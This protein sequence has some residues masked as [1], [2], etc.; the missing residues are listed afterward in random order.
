MNLSYRQLQDRMHR[1]ALGS[2]ARPVAWFAI[3]MMLFFGLM[4]A[5][6]AARLPNAFS[7]NLTVLTLVAVTMCYFLLQDFRAVA[8][9]PQDYEVLGHRPVSPRTYLLVRLTV[10][11][12]QQAIMTALLAGPSAL[13][14]GFRFGWPPA[15]ALFLAALL[16]VFCAV[17]LAL[18]TFATVIEKTGGKW[19]ARALTW[20]QLA[21]I[22]LYIGPLL[23]ES[24]VTALMEG[25]GVG[26]QGWLLALPTAWFAGLAS[27]A[28]GEFT[29]CCWAASAC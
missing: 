10:I 14:C 16:L 22:A 6:L 18:S 9:T 2:K 20:V 12:A 3:V 27:L 25:V 8:V 28:S 29:A 4:I 15:L 24:W 5:N 26:P 21:M 19:L 7:L 23:F 13:V 17:L 11:M 1:G